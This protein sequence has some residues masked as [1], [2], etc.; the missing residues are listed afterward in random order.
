MKIKGTGLMNS[1]KYDG[2]LYEV[3]NI[4][5]LTELLDISVQKFPDRT[6]FMY[7]E[8]RGEEFKTVTYSDFIYYQTALSTAF[9]ELDLRGK[10]VAILGENSFQWALTY[11]AVACAGCIVVPIDSGLKAGEI[12][13]LLK[14]TGTEFFFVSS[15]YAAEYAPMIDEIESLNFM[16]VMGL[17]SEKD[18]QLFRD[19][20][21][22]PF[23]EALRFGE[24]A[25]NSGN[26]SYAENPV[27]PDDL[28]AIIFT[29]GT[30]GMAKG[31]MLTH[32]NLAQN[33]CNMSRV[34]RAPDNTRALDVLP[35]HHTYEM[36]CTIMTGLYQGATIV[37]CEG[38]K[39]VKKNYKEAGCSVMLGVPLL[40]EK[41]HAAIMKKAADTGELKKLKRALRTSKVFKLKNR[42][43]VTKKMF[44]AIHDIF[45][46]NL[47][48]FIVG[49]AAIDP[50]VIKDFELMGIPI[51][52]G[53]GMTECS[54][55]ISV[56]SD[57]YGKIGSVGR[58]LPGTTV[59]IND[60][61]EEGIGEIVC[62][63]PSVMAGYFD[64][65]ENTAKVLKDGRLYTGDFGYLDDD[66]FLYITGRKKNVIV[67][68]NGKNIFPEEVEYYIL[69]EKYVKEVLVYGKEDPG[70][71]GDT[72]CTA[73]IFIDEEE[74]Q[75]DGLVSRSEILN[76]LK[77][78]VDRANDK[79]PD[80]KR[81]KRIE[82]RNREFV[83]TTA[84]KIKRFERENYEFEYDDR[85]A[86]T[87]I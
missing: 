86:D 33:V 11:F 45:G 5:T 9:L 32:R 67:T 40:F 41:I 87:D 28:A 44:K 74:L 58:P 65:E 22:F 50:Q 31:V 79:M 3:Q 56:N 78:S 21:I 73:V 17:T 38:L 6:A 62:S 68:K 4:D 29:S 66:G 1:K 72:Y 84:L 7:R 77:Q 39:Y 13:N 20:R 2:I 36:T 46:D 63:G 26:K 35:M 8:K 16:A 59:E 42:K 19:K 71:G 60:P 64:D 27:K 18:S 43:F 10:C 49:G 51:L 30:T 70:K 69:K 83:K 14:R 82:V 81:V 24:A 85:L 61:D 12:K 34:F 76:A 25:I 53:Y 57:R 23:S 48:C 47:Y 55:L 54:P 37:I 75:E 80:F 15:K 52:Q